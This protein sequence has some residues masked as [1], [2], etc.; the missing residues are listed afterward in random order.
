MT[1]SDSGK[2]KIFGADAAQR[3]REW[4]RDAGR[5][6]TAQM[7]LSVIELQRK[8]FDGTIKGVGKLQDQTG[9]M[10]HKIAQ[11]ASWVPDEG[12]Q[13]VDEWNK[14]THRGREEFQKTMDKSFDLLSH[15][16]ERVKKGAPAAAAKKPA[17]KKRAAAK[18]KPAA[19]AAAE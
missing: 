13:V 16:F 3:A 5:E 15:Y 6:R 8:T 4:T 1:P 17:A 2:R 11:S 18:K 9:K 10:L 14:A 7:A 12:K 19:D